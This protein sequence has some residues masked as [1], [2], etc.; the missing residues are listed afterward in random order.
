M[1][2]KLIPQ[3]Y[4]LKRWPRDE[5]LGCNQNWKGEH[6]ELDIKAHFMKRYNELCPRAVK[7]SNR[8]SESHETYTFLSKVYEESHKI[9]ED[10]LTKKS[11]DGESI[12]MSHVSIS[13][14]NEKTDQNVDTV[15][16]GG[17]KAIKSRDCLD[18]TKKRHPTWL[19]KLDK[20]RQKRL[21]QTKRKKKLVNNSLLSF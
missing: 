3:Q 1:N 15:D 8:A 10:M 11:M 13:I 20:K 6:I 14:A 2:V 17:A 4:I 7:L 5:R 19:E 21:S 12:G 18:R 16:L 9:V